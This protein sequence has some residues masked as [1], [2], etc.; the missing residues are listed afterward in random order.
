MTKYNKIMENVEMSDQ[1]KKDL[2]NGLNKPKKKK[3]WILKNAPAL[4]GVLVI[5]FMFSLCIVNMGINSSNSSAD[6][7]SESV[8][9][10]SAPSESWDAGEWDSAAATDSDFEASGSESIAD[11]SSD[12]IVY[13]ASL[14]METQEY[15]QCVESVRSLIDEYS[16]FTQSETISDNG[17]TLPSCSLDIRIPADSFQSFL[18]ELSGC[19]NITW[20][21]VNAENIT[22]SYTDVQRWIDSLKT[23]E[24]RLNELLSQAEN[25]SDM[26]AI[27]DKLIDV[28]NELRGYEQQLASMDLDVSYSTVYVNIQ[29]VSILTSSDASLSS[30]IGAALSG[31]WNAFVQGLGDL[32][33]GL[34]WALPWIALIA[35]IGLAAWF[36]W[37]KRHK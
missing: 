4:A 23:E 34:I 9:S 27:E 24:A 19:G 15:E 6:T 37:R 21:Y 12:K 11:A 7:S 36:I 16:G 28:E 26:I 30:R 32:L 22:E 8:S 5:V 18:D 3:P 20:Q 35:L 33:I 29:D 1:M 10:D 2:L 31:T 14:D 17:S 25:M 13:T